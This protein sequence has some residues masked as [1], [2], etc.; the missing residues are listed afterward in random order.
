MPKFIHLRNHSE[1][2]LAEGA[3]RIKEMAQ[4]CAARRMPAVAITDSGNLFGIMEFS[5]AC[6]AE[7]VQPIIGCELIVDDYKL[8]LYAKNEE[9]FNNLLKLV[10]KAYLDP[11]HPDKPSLSLRQVDDYSDGLLCL[12]ASTR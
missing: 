3:L 8:V 2:S 4:S 11:L 5:K 9:G 6:I 10:S 12:T 7:G 1:Y